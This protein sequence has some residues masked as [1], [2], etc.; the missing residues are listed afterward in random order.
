MGIDL[1][2]RS[3]PSAIDFALLK[4]G[5]LVELHR[6][7]TGIKFNVGDIFLAKVSKIM[8][9]LNAAFIHLKSKKDGFLH[10]HDLGPNVRSLLKY[11]KLLRSN[12]K[13]HPL[14][15][16]FKFEPKIHKDGS[17]NQ[18]LRQGELILV[19][20]VKEPISTKGPRLT[21]EISLAGRYLVLVPFNE[22]VFVSSKI[23]SE[24]ERS[25]LK[26]LAESI[27]P[28]NFGLI[29]RT[30]ADGKKVAELDKDLNTLISSWEETS[31]NIVTARP[32][33]KVYREI[34][35]AGLLLRDLLD[36]NFESIVVDDK[37]LYNEI[38]QLVR[39]IYPEKEKIVKFYNQKIPIFEKYG[40]EKQIKTSFGRS[41]SLDKG[42][43]IIIEHTEAM[44]VIDVN[45]GL[46]PGKSGD[47][48]NTALQVNLKAAKEIARQ[49]RLRDMGGIIIVDF[50]DLHSQENRKKL[51]EYLKEQMKDDR[52]KHKILPPTK[53]GLIQITR[54]R[55]RPERNIDTSEKNP[56]L[57]FKD[58]V[59][60]P[61]TLISKIEDDLEK[62]VDKT[63][64][65]LILA[66]HPFIAAYLRKGFLSWRWKKIFQY[67]RM[68]DI[69]PRYGYKYLEYRF[70]DK[71][72]NE[73]DLIK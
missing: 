32:P 17:I 42:A 28:K 37:N 70:F 10:Y 7:E 57:V 71:D 44:H 23:E 39:E 63:K 66:V 69:Q 15:K 18:V 6:E 26:R 9:G 21:S 41:V 65:K 27:R 48:E 35:K 50:I 62:I 53:F 49:L 13:I 73:I 5:L 12:K 1:I 19:Q 47:Q 25:R 20:I 59:D 58:Q 3:S 43:Y 22:G 72:G 55:V 24:T 46:S 64:G 56:S 40:I 34:G 31:K 67:K 29:V 16:N 38:L 52:A 54:Q 60:A 14:L 51:Y 36:E 30:A 11:I 33:Q 68:L 2:I 8:P 61:I 4:D 45:S